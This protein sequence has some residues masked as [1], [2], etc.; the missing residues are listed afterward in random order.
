MTPEG[1]PDRDRL[2]ATHSYLVA[3][4]VARYR[5]WRLDR[6]DLHQAGLVGLLVAAARFDPEREVPFAGYARAWV[7]KEIQRAIARQEFPAVLPAELVGRT[8]A[9]RRALDENADRLALA[10]AALGLTPAT[11]LALHRQLDVPGATDEDELPAP[12]YVLAGPEQAVVAADFVTAA[13][14][15]LARMPA[16]QADAFIMRYGLDGGAQRSY[17]EIGRRLA[18]SGHTA[19]ALVER[20]QVCMRQLLD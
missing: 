10:A 8:V 5:T 7:R 15:A 2:V 11:V 19:R 20:A 13:R 16:L 18:V 12:G 14:A 1:R 6:A 3:G 9:L 17:R 4:E